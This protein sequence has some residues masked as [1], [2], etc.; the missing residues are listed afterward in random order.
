M[1]YQPFSKSKRR[2]IWLKTDGGCYYCG[3]DLHALH[4]EGETIKRP[5][6]GFQFMCLDHDLPKS[7]GGTN[8]DENLVPSCRSCNSQ[9]GTKTIA[10][11]R[12]WLSGYLGMRIEFYGDAA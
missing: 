6:R 9:K 7:R 12:A 5:R 10:E 8:A 3:V 11:Y 1:S 4:S 2:R